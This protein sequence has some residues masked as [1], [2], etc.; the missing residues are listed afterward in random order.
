[1]SKALVLQTIEQ[2]WMEHLDTMGDLRLGVGLTSMAQRDP[3]VEYK[4]E[5]GRMFNAML[6]SIDEGV[7]NRF[8]KVRIVQQSETPQGREVKQE[9]DRIGDDVRPGEVGRPVTVKKMGKKPGRNDP[10]PCGSGKKYK[11]CH[12]PQYG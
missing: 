9:V 2:Y 3:L 5:G 7:V 8:F 11:K 10:C 6:A 12:Y 1:L 4:N